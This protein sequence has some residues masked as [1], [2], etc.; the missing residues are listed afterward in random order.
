[1]ILS[2]LDKLFKSFLLY[3]GK[4]ILF[5]RDRNLK[6]DIFTLTL[7]ISLNY[8]NVTLELLIFPGNEDLKKE[9]TLSR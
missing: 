8:L 5:N 2:S 7:C 4:T 9:T 3:L 1:M 6:N